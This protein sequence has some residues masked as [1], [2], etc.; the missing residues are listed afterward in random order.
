MLP[1]SKQIKFQLISIISE[2]MCG[3]TGGQICNHCYEM[4]CFENVLLTTNAQHH[5]LL[6]IFGKIGILFDFSN[7]IYMFTINMPC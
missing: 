3:L 1:G 6:V 4:E 7:A 5:K 2:K